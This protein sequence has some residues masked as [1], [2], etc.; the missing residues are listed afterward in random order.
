VTHGEEG[1]EEERLVE[2]AQI[3]AQLRQRRG[4]RNAPLEEGDC[5][6]RTRRKGRQGE[7]PKA[8]H[9]YRLVQSSQEGEKSPEKEVVALTCRGHSKGTMAVGFG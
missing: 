8:G 9:H 5:K 4:E 7:E 1:S 6:K 3:F 2:E